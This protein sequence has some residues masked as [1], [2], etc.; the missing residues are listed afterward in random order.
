LS[1]RRSPGRVECEV[2]AEAKIPALVV[3]GCGGVALAT[4]SGWAGVTVGVV[5]GLLVLIGT[6][7]FP[8]FRRSVGAHVPATAPL[9]FPLLIL[10]LGLVAGV[11]AASAPWLRGS[12]GLDSSTVQ[13]LTLLA[14]TLAC[15]TAFRGEAFLGSSSGDGETSKRRSRRPRRMMGRSTRR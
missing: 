12:A 3:I 5:A 13:F 2:P 15:A 1:R 9:L 10:L 14:F 6:R 4:M 8:A 11:L 7:A